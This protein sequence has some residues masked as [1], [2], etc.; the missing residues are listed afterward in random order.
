MMAV[1]VVHGMVVYAG[2]P[3]SLG[4]GFESGLSNFRV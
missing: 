3:T 2:V 1:W 4:V